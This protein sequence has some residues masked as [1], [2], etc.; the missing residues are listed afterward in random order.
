MPSRFR[1]AR[2]VVD[3]M[4]RDQ[5]L[6]LDAQMNRVKALGGSRAVLAGIVVVLTLL[7]VVLLLASGA[8]LPGI[9]SSLG[10][11][12]RLW[13]GGSQ[14]GAL[15]H[16]FHLM[17]SPSQ[18]SPSPSLSSL[19]PFS[20]TSD[21]AAV[22]GGGGSADNNLNS[23]AP[24]LIEW[25][26]SN[27][28]VHVIPF[29]SDDIS[30][31]LEGMQQWAELGPA[32][33]PSD[34]AVSL[35]L[36]F[37]HS[38]SKVEYD[39]A[40]TPYLDEL[41]LM[42]PSVMDNVGA[43]YKDMA[44]VFAELQPEED[45]YPE[46]PSNMFFKL[47]TTLAVPLL[48]HATH[49]YWM[50]WD[51]KPVRPMWLDVLYY[52]TMGEPFWIKGGRYRGRA[53]DNAVRDPSSWSWIGHINGNALY[54][55]HDTEFERFMALTIERE[56]PSHFWKPFDIA[57]WKTLLDFPYSWHLYQVYGEKFQTT[58]I[59][60]HLGFTVRDGEREA[61]VRESPNVHLIHGN[62]KSA[63][64]S[65]YLAKFV[66][67]VPQTN[68]TIV[69]QDEVT[70]SMRVSILIRTFGADLPFAYHALQSA[71]RY[72]P[73]A[74]EYVAVVPESDLQLAAS[75]LPS[76][77]TLY[78]E[79]AALHGDHVQQ[80]LTTLL[81]DKYCQGDYI[82]HL[83]SDV[84]FYRPVLRRDLF[85]FDKPI[86][87]FDSYANI[88]ERNTAQAQANTNTKQQQHT[89]R[90]GT[91][92]ALGRSVEF[93]FGRSDDHLFHRMVYNEVRLHMQEL[94]H[95]TVAEFLDTRETLLR[96]DV[97]HPDTADTASED[98]LFSDMNFIGAYL[99]YYHPSIMAWTYLG[100]DKAPQHALPYAYSSVRPPLVCHGNAAAFRRPD[101]QDAAATQIA[102]LQRIASGQSTSQCAEL[103]GFLAYH[104]AL[105]TVLTQ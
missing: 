18:S 98:K 27:H 99:Y 5:W 31:L 43:C 65:K 66:A 15:A 21:V 57:I 24:G 76:F 63:G 80:K 71:K 50:E 104:N 70:S 40:Q 60:Q 83:D 34:P 39:A 45:G 86:I 10:P 81:A 46:G 61:L 49:L 72:F 69:W 100:E 25:S 7:M 82:F 19:S 12:S 91:E 1:T 103:H 77:V 11:L 20:S 17:M 29:I 92:V 8:V 59:I 89:Y 68:A 47:M 79:P 94:H 48:S 90:A 56:P 96:S 62:G 75:S 53:F 51:V 37:F 64:N 26:S 42:Y 54:K 3:R 87:T 52:A 97:V 30:N 38:G 13:S 16:R 41:M 35:S 4:L 32:C 36:R 84:V 102:I 44:T 101:E 9:I 105:S 23:A 85:I 73:G 14:R 74:I 28:L 93:E 6:K 55:L 67:G 78:S 58:S 95:M 88:Q 2:K 33:D 22:G